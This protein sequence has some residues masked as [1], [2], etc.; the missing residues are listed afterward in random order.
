MNQVPF[1]KYIPNDHSRQVTS[2][3]FIDHVFA[4][5]DKIETVMDL[6]CGAGNSLDYFRKKNPNVRWSGLDIESSPEVESRTRTD[7]DFYKYDGVHMLFHDN[8]FD[9]IY[10]N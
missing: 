10:S 7:G 1:G 2:T 5:M 8:H 6:G 3:Y 4:A 9:L